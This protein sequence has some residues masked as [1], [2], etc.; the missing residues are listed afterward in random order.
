[1]KTKAKVAEQLNWDNSYSRLDTLIKAKAYLSEADFYSLFLSSWTDCD[2]TATTYSNIKELFKGVRLGQ[3]MAKYGQGESL[4]HWQGLP[5][6][7]TI[8]RGCYAFNKKGV[9]WTLDKQL[10]VEFTNNHRYRH[11]GHLPALLTATV[12]KSQCFYFAD[13]EEQE[14]FT[15]KAKV[16]NTFL[17]TPNFKKEL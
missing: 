1:M 2:T 7:I 11:E 4:Q 5:D 13:R 3:I 12:K 14:I 9:S 6:E 15:L 10:A 17:P 16:I 8:Y